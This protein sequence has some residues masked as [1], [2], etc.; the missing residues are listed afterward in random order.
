MQYYGRK[1]QCIQGYKVILY[2]YIF[3]I[4]G[5]PQNKIV[6]IDHLHGRDNVSGVYLFQR[7]TKVVTKDRNSAS[8]EAPGGF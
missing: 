4:S 7:L 5:F 6:Q 1:L 3:Q 2:E 8:A